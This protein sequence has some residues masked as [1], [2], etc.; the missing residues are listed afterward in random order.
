ME[1]KD[2]DG[3]EVM[4]FSGLDKGIVLQETRIFSQTPVNVRKCCHLLTKVLY[5]VYQGEKL[6]TN[7]ATDVFFAST[8]LFQS[9]DL[10]LRRLLFLSLKELSV[11]AESVIIVISSLTKDMNSPVDMYRSHAIRVLCKILTDIS[12]LGQGER[13]LKQ[14]I[15]DKEP[16]VQSAALVSGIHLL[17]HAVNN[18]LVKRWFTEIFEASKSRDQMVQY[19]AL[20]LMYQLRKQDRLAVS[21]LI[22][23][24]RK[25][26]KS[27]FALCLLIRYTVQI[28]KEISGDDTIP[29]FDF[30]GSCLRHGN[31]MVTY[32]AAR[33]LTVND[34]PNLPPKLLSTAIAG[35][36]L[37]LNNPKPM[38]RF[39]A[40]RTLNEIALKHKEVQFC[41]TD[42]ENLI[43]DSNR[44]IATLAITTLLKTG[45][46][47]SVDRLIKE[48]S[49]FMGEL[50]D[51]FKVILIGAVRTLCGKFP[52]KH[53]TL[54]TFLADILREEGGFAYKKAIVDAIL[55]I[56]RDVPE[57]K[58]LGLSCMCE[59]IEDCEFPQLSVQ[60][61]DMVGREGPTTPNP[62]RYIRYIYNR[63]I[64]EAEVVRSSAV[65]ALANFGIR[66]PSLRN[67]IIKL[68]QRIVY[69]SDDEVRDRGTFF[70][71]ILQE[72]E[73]NAESYVADLPID[74][75]ELERSLLEYQS[76]TFE[77]PFD[78]DS[79]VSMVIAE[80]PIRH[81]AKESHSDSDGK[82]GGRASSGFEEASAGGP[83]ARLNAIPEFALYGKLFKSSAPVKLSED[84]TEYTVSCIKHIFSK[85]IVFEFQIT[86][87]VNDQELA[88]VSVKMEVDP[89]SE[90]E[91]SSLTPDVEIEIKVL[92]Y[93]SP[94]SCYI[95]FE[96]DPSSIAIGSFSTV[97]KYTAFNLDVSTGERED[98]G[99]EDE[100]PLEELEVAY[101]DY[102]LAA[103]LP[104]FQTDWEKLEKTEA[105]ETFTLNSVKTLAE[106]VQEILKHLSLFPIEG[107]GEVAPKKTKHILFG[108]GIWIGG[109]PV[110]VRARMRINPNN[111]NVDLELTVRSENEEVNG[112]LA[113]SL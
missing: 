30:I 87:T 14:A 110:L 3:E 111:Q 23:T 52:Q 28:L 35:L 42:I 108:S 62:S 60:V 50:S 103:M 63:V 20:G 47:D 44:S 21:K 56:M 5:L 67:S 54:I 8:K 22:G 107:T 32:E 70:L 59:F 48:I 88:D 9:N 93:D 83:A 102:C 17:K 43:S 96:R 79:T 105:I 40:I 89:S 109:F 104:T 85:H 55:G 15:L 90:G 82:K 49:N 106:A 16:A 75:E 69:D 46:V 31:D 6:T 36:Q 34:L 4:P 100:Y 10:F 2:E 39:A 72:N 81:A 112:L 91:L 113:S 76:S 86:N 58:E 25:T 18:E 68:L 41:N 37:L 57:S 95:S 24:V 51:E 26:A 97:L 45:D 53:R 77:A 61:L 29:L 65:Q 19:H 11:M 92:R 74:A 13:Y 101:S 71:K 7:E 12:L 38:Y 78:M 1:K 80:R 64:L 98:D 99:E 73:E 27:P 33:A 66:V 94:A 84:E